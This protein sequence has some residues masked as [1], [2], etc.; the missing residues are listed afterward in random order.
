MHNADSLVYAWYVIDPVSF[1]KVVGENQEGKPSIV[2]IEET[3]GKEY[4]GKIKQ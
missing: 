1:S 2:T 4:P 3:E